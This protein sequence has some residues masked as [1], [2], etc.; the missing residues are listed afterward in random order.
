MN[1]FNDYVKEDS[2][3]TYIDGDT[4][5]NIISNKNINIDMIKDRRRNIIVDSYFDKY[6]ISKT[7][8]NINKYTEYYNDNCIDK[9]K[10][11]KLKKN[12]KNEEHSIFNKS[13][14]DE[15]YEKDKKIHYNQYFGRYKDLEYIKEYYENK[16]QEYDK[17]ID[18]YGQIESEYYDYDSDNSDYEYSETILY[19][20]N[21]SDS[22]DYE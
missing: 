21:E 16:R 20:D 9:I 8:Y 12:N 5:Y 6:N 4:I 22:D 7:T 13:Y 19:D 1:V 15:E 3:N 10:N 2:I 18:S 17:E 14:G 11:L